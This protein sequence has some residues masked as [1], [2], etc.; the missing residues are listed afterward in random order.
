MDGDYWKTIMVTV[1]DENLKALNKEKNPDN[2]ALLLRD[3]LSK[4]LNP[5]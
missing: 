4:A 2:L 5:K 1:L 3:Y